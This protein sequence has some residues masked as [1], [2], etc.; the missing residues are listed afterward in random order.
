MVILHNDIDMPFAKPDAEPVYL[1]QMKALLKRHPTASIIWAHTGLGRV[2]HP[3]QSSEQPAERSPNHVEIVE[4]MLADPSLGHVNF[5][6]S[7]DEVAKY[8]ISS[9]PV[10]ARVAAML[11]K[12]PDRFLFGTDTVAPASAAA[13]F[14]VFEMWDAGLAAADAGGEPQGAKRQLR[15]DVRRGPPA[16][17]RVGAAES[18]VSSLSR[19]APTW[20]DDECSAPGPA[21][22][23]AVDAV[24]GRRPGVR[25]GRRARTA[26]G[27]GRHSRSERHARNLRLRPGRRDRRFQAERP[28]L[29]RRRTVHRDCRTSPDQFGADGH[30]YLSAAAEPPRRQGR[31]ADR[32]RPRERAVRVRHVRRRR[33]RRADHH[34]PAPRVGPV[35]DRSAP[36]RPTASSWTRTSSR[37]SSTTGDRTACCSSAT[38]SCSG[39]RTTTAIRTCVSPSRLRAPA[40]MPAWSRTASS[41]RT[42]KARFPSPD[43]TGHYA[44]GDGAG[45]YFQVGGAL[46]YIAYD[47]TL[48]NDA[49]DLSGHVW[50]WGVSLSSN[51][52]LGKNDIAASP[53]R[54]RR[55]RRELLQRRAGRRR[56]SRA[57]R[58]T[59]SRRSSARRCTTSAS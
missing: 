11:N 34:P 40:A 32:G 53:A 24:A 39:S 21:M 57:T 23:S 8:A 17:P 36:A 44:C 52:K 51:V 27:A 46:R 55:G 22:R 49:F 54:R 29:V 12:Y 33:R 48:P 26:A 9:P 41:C 35:E 37:T 30:F 38:C 3:A 25:A 31:G 14:G 5:D 28:Q 59:R 56:R 47:D 20:T 4:A 18:Q 2:V 58:A 43:F 16:R 45:D 50:G 10:I 1:T 13:Y 42:C 19:G 7:W 6:I 15:A